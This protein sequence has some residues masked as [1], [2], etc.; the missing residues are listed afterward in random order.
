MLSRIECRKFIRHILREG[1]ELN[2][3]RFNVLFDDIDTDKSNTID[4]NE[5]TVFV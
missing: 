5:M 3:E 1:D 2:D 4:R